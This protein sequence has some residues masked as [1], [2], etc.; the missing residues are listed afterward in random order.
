LPDRTDGAV[1]APWAVF[2]PDWYRTQYPDAPNGS[3]DTLLEWHLTRGQTLGHSPNRF[4]DEAWQ[5]QTW[6][7]IL[8]LIEAHSVASAFDAWCLGPHATRPPHWLF[9]PREYRVRYPALTD[10]AL[11]EHR[12]IN[13]Y[14]HY[15]QF[16]AAEGRIGHA[17][18]VPAIYLAELTAA[19]AEAAAAMP[20]R[21]Y[22]HGLENGAPERRTSLLF[23]PVW[24]RE[25]YPEAARSVAAG[26]YRS[27]LEHYLRNDRPTDFDPS[28]WFSESWYLAENP[29]L[30]GSLGPAGF[31]DGFAHFLAFGSREGRSPHPDLDLG[32]YAG[33]DDVRA[34]I[35]A[36]RVQDAFMHWITIGQPSGLVGRAPPVITITEAHAVALYQ[37]RAN[38]VW[39]LFGR[40]KLDF[41]RDGTPAV[42][43]IM[44][45]RH[46][47]AETMMS[48]ASVK[49]H[50]HGEI[51]LIL[52]DSGS[53]S[54]GVDIETHVTG[55]TILRFGTM[56][57]DSAS[58]EAG[59]ICATAEMVLLLADG[60]ALA[61]GA[62]DSALARLANDPTIGAV[63]ARL[64]QPHGVLLEAGGII[65][66]DGHLQPYARDAAATA[67]EANFV[68]DTDF[69]STSCLLARRELLSSLPDQA[70]GIAGTTHDAA[71]L[72]VRIQQAGFRVVYDPDMAA[73]LT[74]QAP[75]QR[76]DGRAA[77]VA[78]HSDDSA[79]RPPFDAEA[80]IR[81]RFPRQ[82]QTR[83]LFVEDAIPL[84]R[85][86]SGFVRSNDVVRALVASGAFVTVFPM[87]AAPFPLSIV[88]A[89]L[90]DSVEVMHDLTAADFANFVTERRGCYDLVWIARTHN[91]DLIHEA[92]ISTPPGV[93]TEPAASLSR[94]EVPRGTRLRSTENRRR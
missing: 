87:K 44:T 84:R 83:V 34:D 91:L 2:D 79:A 35:A 12:L 66:R 70:D 48:L 86:G 33:R 85:I 88:R 59:L 56:L 29:G 69:C 94:T 80:A 36:E 47:F 20:F 89:E 10:E 15:L 51:E 72:C 6:P 92:L 57:N 93:A 42:S 17:L 64:I 18:F 46:Q 19:E 41:T 62:I 23:D 77:F 60:V 45:P 71:D 9:N 22:L 52:I 65:W 68:R 73:F 24:Y 16:G 8:A 55:A 14:H 40:H 3:A 50:F 11:V 78:A 67:A 75:D 21:H 1:D 49:A 32:W 61:P 43:V 7:G 31:R 74:T 53:M 38:I 58:R 76:P 30:A 27:L 82:G 63:G 28:P 13:Q 5:R 90:P 81:A 37:Q 4:F 25:R 54:P 26:R 39:P